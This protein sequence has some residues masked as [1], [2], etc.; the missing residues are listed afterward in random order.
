MSIQKTQTEGRVNVALGQQSLTELARLAKKHGTS[1]GSLARA[2]I[3]DGMERL[4]SG[5]IEV[6]AGVSVIPNKATP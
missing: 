1:R 3:Q 6:A 4:K 2:F 5:K